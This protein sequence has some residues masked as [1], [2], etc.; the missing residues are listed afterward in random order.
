M[1]R[2]KLM[3]ALLQMEQ[4][5]NV[6]D[7]MKQELYR[8]QEAL[9]SL[10]IAFL[11]V[12]VYN[13]QYSELL[14]LTIF[15]HH[16]YKALIIVTDNYTEHNEDIHVVNQVNVVGQE[17]VASSAVPPNSPE[18]A[19]FEPAKAGVFAAGDSYESVE[20]MKHTSMEEKVKDYIKEGLLDEKTV[21]SVLQSQKDQ[22]MEK[23]SQMGLERMTTKEY[24]PTTLENV[25]G[26]T[27][28]NSVENMETHESVNF[29]SPSVQ[30]QKSF[31]KRIE[32]YLKQR[33]DENARQLM[34][35]EQL[36]VRQNEIVA[37]E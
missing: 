26:F 17:K 23:Y 10:L 32:E 34:H 30:A 36:D 5:Y 15:G 33:E 11:M 12:L 4:A 18:I 2:Q 7:G 21:Q 31:D 37:A 29:P 25:E 20:D 9:R 13:A 19:G 22:I 1:Y 35:E 16:F 28:M 6:L 14:T 27:D 24:D 8:N 3:K